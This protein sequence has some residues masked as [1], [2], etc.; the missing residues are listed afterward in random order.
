[1]TTPTWTINGTPLAS[2]GIS[3]LR[4]TFRSRAADTAEFDVAGD[5]D[6]NPAYAYNAEITIALGGDTKFRGRIATIPRQ[7]S[8]TE[9]YIRYVAKGPWADLERAMYTQTFKAGASSLASVETRCILGIG[10]AGSPAALTPVSYNAQIGDIL[11]AARSRGANLDDG[12]ISVS[13]RTMP[14]DEQVDLT[15]AAA[16]ERC[17]S[18]FPDTVT[19]F[20]YSTTPKPTLHIKRRS[21]LTSKSISALE[22]ES[23][24]I[25]PRNDL[26][27][28]GVRIIYEH[29]TSTD[30]DGYRTTSAD[31]AGRPDDLGS[32]VHTVQLDGGSMSTEWEKIESVALP[33]SLTSNAAKAW[34]L[35]KIPEL[36]GWS[37][38]TLH[39]SVT[40]YPPR[41]ASGDTLNREL[42]SGTIQPWMTGD[43]AEQRTLTV[44][45]DYTLGGVEYVNQTLSVTLTLTDA[46]G[47]RS[48]QTGTYSQPVPANGLAAEIYAAHSVL[49]YEGSIT[50]VQ[51]TPDFAISPGNKL[52]ITGGRSGWASM[53]AVVQSVQISVDT[54]T[55][56]ITFGPPQHLG[57]ADLV[58]ATLP[59]RKRAMVRSAKALTSA[60]ASS[61]ASVNCPKGQV[62]NSTAG[63]AYRAKITV[64]DPAQSSVN[65]VADG[66]AGTLSATN[67][68][69]TLTIDPDATPEVFTVISGIRS[70]DLTY[71]RG[72]IGGS[73][74]A[75]TLIITK[76]SNAIKS[77]AHGND[78][79][80]PVENGVEGYEVSLLDEIFVED[81]A[82]KAH[83]S[84]AWS[85]YEDSDADPAITTE[86]TGQSCAPEG[87][88]ETPAEE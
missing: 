35:A 12:N 30:S 16:L 24:S 47:L 7:G 20:D 85:P 15:C 76:V 36:A 5:Y 17:L 78:V 68:G 73:I 9:E 56:T 21:S 34:W 27:V 86:I 11:A 61:S 29:T 74:T 82:I 62:I 59:N 54:G 2:A 38:I 31:E 48:H 63:G 88:D 84:V 70:W 79:R 23:I 81:N 49:H 64:Q 25:T 58:Q 8:G 67:A 14:A 87:D 80:I 71:L 51:A 66:T 13:S 50:Y 37:D 19:W 28:P 40:P 3:N 46:S 42:I 65:V 72:S 4:L 77:I 26:V 75:R 6:G 22:A 45:A 52:N 43:H 69:G 83:R 55:T 41:A 44:L 53:N 39:D 57:V 18:W 60:S 10:V 32:I 33:A 1:M